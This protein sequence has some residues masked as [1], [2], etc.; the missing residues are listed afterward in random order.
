MD[1]RYEVIPYETR[2]VGSQR[3]KLSKEVV[4][5][6]CQQSKK[7]LTSSTLLPKAGSIRNRCPA[8]ILRHPTEQGVH[9]GTVRAG[10]SKSGNS[11][12]EEPE[13]ETPG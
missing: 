3:L 11:Q 8:H 13:V 7:P 2:Y 6:E 4:V 1:T 9:R 12:V 5:V 10:S